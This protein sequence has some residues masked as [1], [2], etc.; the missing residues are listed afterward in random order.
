LK[1]ALI[2]FRP[3]RS[4]ALALFLHTPNHYHF[5]LLR[6]GQF[7][8]HGSQASIRLDGEGMWCLLIYSIAMPSPLLKRVPD[9]INLR[10]VCHDAF[11]TAT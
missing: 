2:S 7:P 4:L 9:F 1:F 11:V 3:T 8:R 10:Y 5:G 6:F